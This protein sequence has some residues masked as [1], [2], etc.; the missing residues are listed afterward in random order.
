MATTSNILPASVSKAR[1]GLLKRLGPRHA[2]VALLL[3]LLGA[4]AYAYR[5]YTGFT[6]GMYN[7]MRGASVRENRNLWFLIGY[8]LEYMQLLQYDE[9][10]GFYTF[11]LVDERGMGDFD[12]GKLAFHRGQFDRAAALIERDIERDGETEMK[13]FWLGMSYLRNAE[14]DNCLAKLSAGAAPGGGPGRRAHEAQP[15]EVAQHPAG[16]HDH[17]AQLMCALPLTRFHEHDESARAAAKAFEKLLDRYDSS[18]RLYQWLLNFN[19]MTVGGFPQE[20]PAKYLIKSDFIDTFYGERGKAVAARY[21]HLSFAERARELGVDTFNAGKGVAVEDF[22]GDGYL[23]IVTGGNFD[24][25]KFYHNEGGRKFTDRT[26]EAGLDGIKQPFVISSADYDND[27]WVDIFFARP[28]G[29]YALYRNRGD[30]TFA[31]VTAS[32]GLLD[33]KPA[34]HIAA[35][36]VATWGDVDNDGDLDL[37]LAQ[38]GFKMPFVRNLMARPRMDSALFINEGGRFVQRAKQ[39]GLASTVE[40]QY[41]IGAAF[42]DYDRDGFP[43]LF[44]SSPLRHTSVLLHNVAG[45]GFEPTDLISRGEGGFVSSFLDFNHDGRLDVYQAGFADAKSSVEQVVFG[46]HRDTYHSGRTT[47]FLQTPDGK[48]QER[49]DLFDMPAS[50]M[51]SSFGDINNDGCYDF[52]LGTGTPEAWFILPKL[53]YVSE[54]EGTRCTE[55]LT[56]ISML[57]G[58]GSIQKG[59]G[60]VFF[61]FDNDGDEDIYSSLGGMWPADR[62]PNQFFV[63]GSEQK[64]SWVTIRLRGR[65]TNHFGVGATIKV[66]AENVRGE[67]IVRYALVDQRTGFGSSPYLAHVGLLDAARIRYAEVYWPASGCLKAY[68]AQLGKSNILDEGDCLPQPSSPPG[69]GEGGGQ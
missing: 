18:N 10:T 41:Y 31:D 62:W 39:W 28:F 56:N 38:W 15:P 63:N 43:D 46:E 23:D 55:R 7:Q 45:R 34:D 42:G 52:Y 26:K 32:S 44:L 13:L 47:I 25:V 12:K 24:L 1:S 22:D 20:V 9:A 61:D 51:G 29:N 6:T 37:F 17:D 48:F 65:R 5:S 21:A 35:T 50:T 33:A 53:M 11:D 64:N 49:A 2:F 8:W 27:G 68:P 58:L 69:G 66:V 40:D 59:H 54:S 30:G 4:G 3:A 67:E 36:W 19:Y 57:H 14:A 60:I 16:A